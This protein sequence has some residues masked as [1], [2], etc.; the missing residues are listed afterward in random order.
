MA[1]FYE[2]N[3][4]FFAINYSRK[5][6][7]SWSKYTFD[8]EIIYIIGYRFFSINFEYDISYLVV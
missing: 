2:Y 6:T 3:E 7:I 4:R 5:K 8:L 1:R